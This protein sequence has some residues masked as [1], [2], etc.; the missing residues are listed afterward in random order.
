M[1]I[2][3]KAVNGEGLAKIFQLIRDNHY[4]K[5]EVMEIVNNAFDGDD[6]VTKPQQEE[7]LNYIRFSNPMSKEEFLSMDKYDEHTLYF[8]TEE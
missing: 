5:E 7:R 1:D 3:D 6:Y 8:I 2:N 4:T